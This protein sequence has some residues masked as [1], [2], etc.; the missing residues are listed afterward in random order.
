MHALTPEQVVVTNGGDELLRLA[1]TTFLEPGRPLGVLSPSYGLYAV[2][3]DIHGASLDT[4]PLSEDWQ[5]PERTADQ[6]NRAGA[7]LA[8]VT[9]PHAPS[10]S[11][12]S[13]ARLDR[14]AADFHGVLL[15]D[16][17]YVDFV[18]P[19]LRHDA[20]TVIRN[21]PNVL[22]LRSLSKGYSLAGLRLAYGLG[23]PELIAPIVSKTK[24]S[25]NVDALAQELGA[26]S[27]V[28]RAGAASTWAAVRDARGRLREALSAMALHS[29]PSHA[30]FLLVSVPEA[31][32]TAEDLLKKLADRQIHVRWFSDKRLRN[33]LRITIGTPEENNEL[34]NALHNIYGRRAE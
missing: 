23:A 3:A 4:V 8:I 6:W 21:R 27:L 24:D 7:Q 10:G 30:N 18:D 12:T 25:Y 22:L 34:V 16:E 5:I 14:L 1:L 19:V 31:W 15:I 11:L 26:A 20:T 2:L 17:A 13:V 33:Y 28:Y 9:N 29:A 32:G